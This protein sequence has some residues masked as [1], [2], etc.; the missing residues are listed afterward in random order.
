ML[1]QILTIDNTYPNG[2]ILGANL[3]SKKPSIENFF[4]I[5]EKFQ[6]RIFEQSHKIVIL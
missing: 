5:K 6:E 4:T 1:E 3:K 2:N